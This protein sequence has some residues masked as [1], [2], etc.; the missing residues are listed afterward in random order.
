LKIQKRSKRLSSLK[1][2]S[3]TV[4]EKILRR[5]SKNKKE[6]PNFIGTNNEEGD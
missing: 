6:L 3:K 5:E 4:L 1:E 2:T